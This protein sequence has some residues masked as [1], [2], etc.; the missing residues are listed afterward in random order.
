MSEYFKN[1]NEINYEV[2]DSENSLSL[3]HYHETKKIS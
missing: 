2:L 1:I 3:E